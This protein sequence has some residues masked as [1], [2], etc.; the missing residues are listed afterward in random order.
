METELFRIRMC[1]VVWSVHDWWV[2]G[3]SCCCSQLQCCVS[4]MAAG[5]IRSASCDGVELQHPTAPNI[6]F[7]HSLMYSCE[8]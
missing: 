8:Q 4:A 3:C 5:M 6:A 1:G 7:M 2:C